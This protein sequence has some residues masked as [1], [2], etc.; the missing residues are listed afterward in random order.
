MKEDHVDAGELRRAPDLLLDD[1]ARV[2]DELDAQPSGLLARVAD[3]HAAGLEG[4]LTLVEGAVHLSGERGDRLRDL[5]VVRLGDV[6]EGGVALEVDQL[7]RRRGLDHGFQQAVGVV[8]RVHE[9]QL[10][11]PHEARVAADVCHDDERPH[12]PDPKRARAGGT[13]RGSRR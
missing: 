1:L 11:E 12:V 4:G 6:E 2:G 3:A 5:L 10:V 9:A 8:L 7:E 13:A